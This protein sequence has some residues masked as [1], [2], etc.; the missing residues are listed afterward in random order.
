MSQGLPVT[1]DNP[2]IVLTELD[3]TPVP[4]GQLEADHPYVVNARIS[5]ASSYP[6]LGVEV[7]CAFRDW[8]LAGPWLPVELTPGGIERVVGLH[9]ARW[10]SANAAFRWRTPP[11]AGHFC[12]RVSCHH[13]D[14]KNPANNVGQEN[15]QVIEGAPGATVGA[16]MLVENPAP[17]PSRLAVAADTYRI[18]RQ[19]WEFRRITVTRE[20]GGDAVRV[21]DEP[22]EPIPLSMGRRLGRWVVHPD[23]TV[24][25]VTRQFYEGRDRLYE[26]QRRARTP[27]PAGWEIS[28]D[29][30][31]AQ[32]G[33]VLGP[34]ER[35][36]VELRIRIPPEAAP[37]TELAIN[38][39]ATDAVRGGLNGVTVIL[40]VT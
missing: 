27:V 23:A 29:A 15:T 18:P 9:I 28:F 8:G 40:R 35:R 31:P 7:R 3:G 33:I 30:E 4:S 20:L 11:T 16:R 34:E 10:A 21:E 22:G 32:A 6:A 14:D 13:P 39:A 24:P 2:D 26:A 1:W 17:L 12:L 37:G 19:E 25:R 38:V 5:N 36:E